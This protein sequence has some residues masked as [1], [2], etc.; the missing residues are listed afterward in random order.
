[1]SNLNKVTDFTGTMDDLFGYK[2][3]PTPLTRRQINIAQ[4]PKKNGSANTDSIPYLKELGVAI[5]D[6]PQEIQFNTNSKELVHRWSPY[7]QGFSSSFVQGIFQRYGSEYANPVVLDPFS[8]S[9]TV[10]VQSKINGFQSHGIE[11]NP[12]LHFTG[13]AKV[14]TWNAD[15][16]KLMHIIKG[17]SKT[18]HFS[19]PEFLKSSRHFKSSVLKKLERLKGSIDSFE[20]SNSSETSIKKLLLLA[21]S[22]II[23]ECSNLKRSPCLGYCK[24]KNVDENTPEILFRKKISE[25]VEDLTA[26]REIYSDKINTPGIIFHANSL[27]HEYDKMY[28]LVITS[29]PYMN[30]LDYVMNYKIEMGWLG[31]ADS[32]AQLKKVKD[33]MVVCDNVSKGLVRDFSFQKTR[34]TSDWIEDI[35]KHISINIEIRGN[36][37]RKDMPE[38]V[39]KYFD[40]MYRIMKKVVE[41]IKPEGRFILVVGDSLIADTYVPTDLIIAQ[42]GKYL[43]MRI[44]GIEKA[45]NRRSGQI[46]SYKLRETVVTL[47]KD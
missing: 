44:E 1:M 40:D 29:P 46:R 30:G 3:L 9:G 19:P 31:F 38:I 22:S 36:Y 26:I 25:I 47:K 41:R 8:G 7:V 45:R 33:E 4:S 5:V 42:I 16:D 20:A 11:L 13:D 18:K 24:S 6:S 12:L 2:S 43:G 21:F 32:H 28:D 34:Y 17:L 10:I 23:I 39:H 37:R 14:N 35:K 15:P 27:H